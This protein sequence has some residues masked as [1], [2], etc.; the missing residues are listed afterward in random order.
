MRLKH[1]WPLADKIESQAAGVLSECRL[2]ACLFELDP[3]DVEAEAR[4]LLANPERGLELPVELTPEWIEGERLDLLRTAARRAAVCG[5]DEA[6]ARA[7]A[8]RQAAGLRDALA[9]QRALA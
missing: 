7:Y 2:L 9:A 6:G 5:L 4:L 3:A 1:L 8:E